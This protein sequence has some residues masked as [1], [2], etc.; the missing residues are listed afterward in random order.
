MRIPVLAIGTAFAMALAAGS[1]EAQAPAPKIWD[2][3][4]GIPISA[5]PLNDF[6]DTACGTNGGPPA[7][8]LKSFYDFAQC[9]VEPRTGLHEVWFRYDDE[10]EYVAR[11]RRSDIMV[12]QYQANAL[13][14]QP[15]VTSLLI[16]DAGIVQGYRVVNDPRADARSRIGAFG[17]ADI[18]KGMSATPL[19]C[20]DLPPAEGERPIEDLL[21][22]ESCESRSDGFMTRVEA[23]RYYKPGQFAVDPNDSRLNEN[24]FESSARIEVYRPGR[25]AQD[26]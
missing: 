14:G 8:V 3:K 20:V 15:I 7:L 11:A 25:A 24:E 16:D 18:F 21:V 10:M 19:E 17:L 12:R 23:R 13:A 5:L 1:A 9:K 6:V 26:R 2:I 4:L 22:K